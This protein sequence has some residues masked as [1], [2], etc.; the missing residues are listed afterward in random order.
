MDGDNVITDKDQCV[1]GDPNPDLSLGLN[2]NVTWKRLT[3]ST[4][5]TGEFGFD[6]YNTTKRQLTL[7][8]YGGT[9]TNRS[10]D[11]LNAWSP[12]NTSASI[13]AL[14]LDD[15]NNEARMSTYYVEDGSYLKMK[16]IKLQYELPSH[17]LKCIGAS[18]LSVYGQMENVFTITDYSGLDP[19]LP[20]GAYGARLDNGPY[21]RSR[22][23]TVGVN[24]QF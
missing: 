7:M 13:P 24:L 21:P 17:W 6:I 10:K 12:T 11:V 1:I 5:L 23:F 14:S 3:L 16:F 9:S 19:E 22:T 2:L 4:F 20:M 15:N 18:A 8:S